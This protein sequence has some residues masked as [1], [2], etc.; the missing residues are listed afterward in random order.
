MTKASIA[1]LLLLLAAP[2][3]AQEVKT[4]KP[5]PAI[6]AKT[7][8]PANSLDQQSP[9]TASANPVASLPAG[10][11]IHMRLETAVSTS[12]SHAGDPFAGRVIQ[13][14]SYNGAVVIP[15]GASV[16]GKVVRVLEQRRIHGKP[17][18]EL[19][20]DRVVLPNGSEYAINAVVTDTAKASGT[21]V[22]E[23]GR[24]KGAGMDKRDKI[25]MAG[26]TAAGAGIG[27]WAGGAKG[28][29]IGA[30]VGGGSALVYW[31]SKHKSAD[32]APGTE[33][34]IE[35]NRPVALSESSD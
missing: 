34:W 22:D 14:V 8:T 10:T 23:E 4:S 26:G 18:I 19:K 35:L 30:A 12:T 21:S 15:V 32:L 7:P 16:K 20:P 11:E 6:N 2:V 5:S 9:R 24:I 1:A 3:S 33:I 31:L 29:L 13:D 27:A 25:E 28:S 17:V